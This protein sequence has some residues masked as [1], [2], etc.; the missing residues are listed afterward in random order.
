[1]VD[2]RRGDDNGGCTTI[3]QGLGIISQYHKVV[4]WPHWDAYLVGGHRW[5]A[6][7]PFVHKVARCTEVGLILKDLQAQGGHAGWVNGT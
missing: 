4:L 6:L 3:S 7:A 5:G 2:A 1:M